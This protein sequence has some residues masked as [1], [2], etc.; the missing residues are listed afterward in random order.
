MKGT[1][2]SQSSDAVWVKFKPFGSM[3]LNA[4]ILFW[5]QMMA[6]QSVRYHADA[7]GKEATA[8]RSWSPDG[9]ETLNNCFWFP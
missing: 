6:R 3:N 8:A 1:T 9:L 5:S 2:Y 4:I 7:S